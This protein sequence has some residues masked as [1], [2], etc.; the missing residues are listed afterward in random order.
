M[1]FRRRPGVLAAAA[2]C[3]ALSVAGCSAP[4]VNHSATDKAGGPVACS[5]DGMKL[6]TAGKLTIATDN[7]ALEPW[8]I[9]NDPTTGEGF[10]SAIGYEIAV[11]L[12][13]D[14]HNVQWRRVKFDKIIAPG[15]KNFDFALDEVTIRDDR[16]KAV[17]FS[18]SYFDVTQG[19]V[20]LSHGKFASAK[21]LSQLRSAKLGAR[22]GTTSLTAIGEAI[23]P[24]TPARSFASMQDAIDA[25][26][27]GTID[28]LVTDLPTAFYIAQGRLADSVVIGQIPAATD[29]EQIGAVL[30]KNSTNTACVDEALATMRANG[31]L[32]ELKQRWIVYRGAPIL[33]NG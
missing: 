26:H 1:N 2:V 3:A 24:T 7:P 23:K 13:F 15:A 16:K 19:V 4:G 6:V 27:S 32:D 9:G 33:K 20:G 11:A 30:P 18:T 17:D 28:A 12:G 10:E 21:S 22:A 25:V 8:F 29:A 31:K 14:P 5:P